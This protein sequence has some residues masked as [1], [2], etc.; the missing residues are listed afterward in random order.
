MVMKALSGKGVQGVNSLKFRLYKLD[1]SGQQLSSSVMFPKDMLPF[2]KFKY[3]STNAGPTVS[4]RA[5]S[6]WAN[7]SVNDIIDIS[8]ATYVVDGVDYLWIK[9]TALATDVYAEIEL[10]N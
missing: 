10:L 9:C 3:V 6:G 7:I 1:G 5:S 2:T 8:N 4:Y